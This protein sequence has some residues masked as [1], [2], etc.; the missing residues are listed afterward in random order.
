MWHLVKYIC[1]QW[2][3]KTHGTI[4]LEQT[5][6]GTTWRA[7]DM[8]KAFK[9]LELNFKSEKSKNQTNYLFMKHLNSGGYSAFKQVAV[10]NALRDCGVKIDGNTRQTAKKFLG[11]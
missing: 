3:M 9:D 8:R 4:L 11:I 10:L 6:N 2:V 7:T 1:F 5:R